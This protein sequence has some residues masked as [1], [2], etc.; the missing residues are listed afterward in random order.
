MERAEG[1]QTEGLTLRHSREV[2]EA[3]VTGER[4]GL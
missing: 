2:W 4:L 3:M 1:K